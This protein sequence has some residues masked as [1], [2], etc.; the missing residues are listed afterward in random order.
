MLLFM[1]KEY[2]DLWVRYTW[3]IPPPPVDGYVVCF[4]FLTVRNNVAANT[5]V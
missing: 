5:H 1:A 3:L 2:S 4:Y